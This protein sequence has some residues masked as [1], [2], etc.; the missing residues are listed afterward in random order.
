MQLLAFLRPYFRLP[1][2]L[3]AL[4]VTVIV[5]CAQEPRTAGAGERTEWSG[6]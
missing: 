3:A 6:R 1:S 4:A 2:V 5:A